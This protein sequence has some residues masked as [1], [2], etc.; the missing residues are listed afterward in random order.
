VRY[1][2][3]PSAGGPPTPPTTITL[4]YNPLIGALSA[5]Y[6][7]QVAPHVSM[8]TRFG[9]NINSYES[10][11][12]I[13]GEWWVGRRGRQRQVELSPEARLQ[14]AKLAAIG[15]RLRDEPATE[16]RHSSP[17]AAVHGD[18][19]QLEAQAR[20][21]ARALDNPDERDGVLKARLSGNWSLA[22]LYEAR[23]RKCLVSVG[24]VSDVFGGAGRA[25]RGV[26]LEVQYYS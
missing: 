13:G 9:V 3:L 19:A 17:V 21:D 10:D 5:S 14:M 15:G 1:T 16:V 20:R 6:A 12:A 23:I 2:S 8:A 25:I 18:E 11:F 26:G 7:A 4:L 22:L 24:L